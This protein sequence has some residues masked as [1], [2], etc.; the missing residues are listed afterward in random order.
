MYKVQKL[1]IHSFKHHWQHPLKSTVRAVKLRK[2]WMG[3]TECIAGVRNVN[4]VLVGKLQRNKPFWKCTCYV[5][6]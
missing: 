6:G 3:H 5:G 4:T 2:M 1:K